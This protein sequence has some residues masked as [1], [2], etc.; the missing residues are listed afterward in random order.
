MTSV[1]CKD[2]VAES[3]FQVRG[4]W[5]GNVIAS[6][7]PGLLSSPAEGVAIREIVAR[8]LRSP[9]LLP[10]GLDPGGRNN[11]RGATP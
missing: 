1:F 8:A 10:S 6:P 11:D 3:A 4:A 2:I 7:T 5:S 9:G